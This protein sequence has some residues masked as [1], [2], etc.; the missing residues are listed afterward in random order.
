MP[1]EEDAPPD[2][3]VPSAQPAAPRC[4][5]RACRGLFFSFRA[6]LEEQFHQHHYMSLRS[7]VLTV[8]AV[9]VALNIY[10]CALGV[11]LLRVGVD[12]YSARFE[13]LWDFYLWSCS[14]PSLLSTAIVQPVVEGA[15]CLALAL[16]WR[17]AFGEGRNATTRY[18]RNLV[19]SFLAILV[20]TVL[21]A[22]FDQ[23][24]KI[25]K[26]ATGQLCMVLLIFVV[27]LRPLVA[28]SIAICGVVLA[29][30]TIRIL[31]GGI[32]CDTV[33]DV[34]MIFAMMCLNLGTTVAEHERVERAHFVAVK[35]A[36]ASH[37]TLLGLLDRLLPP[38]MAA[39][40]VKHWGKKVAISE[41][42]AA[43]TVLFVELLLP[44]A[45]ALP[46]LVDLNRLFILMDT[47]VDTSAGVCKIET[48]GGQF[49]VAS[50]VPNASARHAQEMTELALKMRAAL[51]SACWS[52]G[53]PVAHRIGV[54]SG[55]IGGLPR[56]PGSSTSTKH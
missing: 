42:H 4:S 56:L 32:Q 36:R 54:H 35:L 23:D 47:I 50:G 30:F 20:F 19:L 6:G 1:T 12:E 55:P 45:D 22:L 48:V 7:T 8:A 10:K 13:L 16:C 3:E 46:I 24:G 33:G 52:G 17:R 14:R 9:G 26:C 5:P 53:Q 49:V 18:M 29:A 40:L 41:H 51:M 21:L 44:Q 43:A 28:H 34:A 37:D 31:T 39:E 11:V 38:Q 15:A 25:G 27:P 2:H